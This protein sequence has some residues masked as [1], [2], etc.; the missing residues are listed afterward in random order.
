[1]NA[2]LENPVLAESVP[3]PGKLKTAKILIV[4]DEPPVRRFIESTL[5]AVGY[6]QI[7]FGTSGS[8]VPSLAC[9]ERPD[10]IIMDVM[11]PGGNGLKA[12][13]ILRH[14]KETAAIPVI[15]TSGFNVRTWRQKARNG[16]NMCWRSHFRPRSCC[17]RSR[18]FWTPDP[19]R[20]KT[21][22]GISGG[23]VPDGVVS[24]W[25]TIRLADAVFLI[26]FEDFQFLRDFIGIVGSRWFGWIR[27]DWWFGRG[28]VVSGA[29][30]PLWRLRQP[31]S[32]RLPDRL[33]FPCLPCCWPA[34]RTWGRRVTSIR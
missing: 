5:R 16:R 3:I 17:S 30:Q 27:G 6:Q 22:A 23:R 29:V 24:I 31:R 2:T 4:D 18:P 11:M 12:L 32:G 14:A 9:N 20:R 33:P 19:E 28:F 7:I 26:Q 21:P 15:I 13:R 25:T 1:M 8:A 10:L 34:N